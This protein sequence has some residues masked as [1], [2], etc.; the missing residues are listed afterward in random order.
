MVS[1]PKNTKFFDAGG[2]GAGA[3]GESGVTP[4]DFGFSGRAEYLL[5]GNRTDAFNPF[6]EYEQFTSLHAR[7]D[8]LV[9][10][11]GADYSQAN[12]N[13]LLA[14]SVDLQYNSVCGFSAYAAYLGT[15]RSLHTNQGVAPGYCY[16][17]ACRRPSGLPHRSTLRALRSL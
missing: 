10:G 11:G 14:H 17:R 4:T 8:I 9:L 16:D 3:G 5:I 12:S 7:Q 1:I 13:N 6:N 2:V 15:Y